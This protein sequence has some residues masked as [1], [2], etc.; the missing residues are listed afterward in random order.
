MVRRDVSRRA[1]GRRRGGEG[2][3][4]PHAV[5]HAGRLPVL[6]AARHGE[7]AGAADR[8]E[9]A[10]P[11]RAGGDQ[12]LGRSRGHA[13][14]RPQASGEALRRRAEGAV[15]AHALVLRRARRARLQDR[16]LP[17]AAGILDRARR[18][19]SKLSE[20]GFG[21]WRRGSVRPDVERQPRTRARGPAGLTRSASAPQ[22]AP[23]S[24]H[25]GRSPPS[26]AGSASAPK[27][28]RKHSCTR[29]AS[30][31]AIWRC[32]S[33]DISAAKARTASAR[34][35]VATSL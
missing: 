30:R 1:R 18:R 34:A 22:L 20:G 24:G 8:G 32:S 3:Q 2:R 25:G 12:Y 16:G 28:A 33:A 27:P 14:R 15:H 35:F 31:R 10:A 23:I 29:S 9:D 21:R 19:V 4:A 7:L 11:F 6:Q 13:R 5:L 26:S 17:A